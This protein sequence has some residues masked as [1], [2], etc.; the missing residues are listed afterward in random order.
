MSHLCAIY[1]FHNTKQRTKLKKSFE[2]YKTLKKKFAWRTSVEPNK[3]VLKLIR[4]IN[5]YKN[6][7]IMKCKR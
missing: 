7:K 1:L 3:S 2:Y 4:Y 5:I 6:D